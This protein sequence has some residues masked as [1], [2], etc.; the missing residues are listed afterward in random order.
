MAEAQDQ[1]FIRKIKYILIIFTF[2]S[3][4]SYEFSLSSMGSQ[5]AMFLEINEKNVIL[6]RNL[7]KFQSE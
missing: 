6:G 5:I 1:Y 3:S 2:I 7:R 4:S